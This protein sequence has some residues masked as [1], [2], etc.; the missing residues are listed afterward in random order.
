MVISLMKCT[1]TQRLSAKRSTTSL[2]GG[3][4]AAGQRGGMARRGAHHVVA[5][6]QVTHAAQAYL[7][8]AGQAARLRRVRRGTQGHARVRRDTQGW[9]HTNLKHA[10][11]I[12][13]DQRRA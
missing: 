3:A 11:P 10:L 13:C 2:N 4:C 12:H 1:N 6:T 7:A 5:Q 8:H 9:E